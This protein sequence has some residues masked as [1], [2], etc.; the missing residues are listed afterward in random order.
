[1][2]EF[3]VETTD[4]KTLS[5]VFKF[6]PQQN[7]YCNPVYSYDFFNKHFES[8]I[9]DTDALRRECF[10]LRYEVYC[11]E[12]KGFE[13]PRVF[14]DRL[15]HDE[16]DQ[17][18]MH[19]LLRHR[20]T[21]TFVGTSRLIFQTKAAQGNSLPVKR[22]ARENGLVLPELFDPHEVVEIS[23]FCICKKFRQ[24]INDSLALVKINGGEGGDEIRR[25]IP[26]ISVGLLK[27]MFFLLKEH[28][29]KQVC[30]VLDPVF[31]RMLG[32]LGLHFTKLGPVV[33]YHGKR[34]ICYQTYET[35]IDRL[36]QERSDVWDLATEKGQHVPAIRTNLP[37][38]VPKKSMAGPSPAP[39]SYEDAFSR[40]LGWVTEQEQ[41]TLRGKRIAIAGMGGVGGSHLLAMTRLGI[42]AFN[43]ADF[44]R[45]EL[46]NFNRQ[47]GAKLS[48]L[49]LRKA[50]VL[51]GMAKDINPEL[52]LNI[53]S[54][55]VT[56]ENLDAFLDG[57]AVYVDG[58]DFFVLDVRRKIFARCRELGIPAI[59]AA[60]AGMGV[61]YLVFTRNGMSFE[62]YF[63]MRDLPKAKQLVR[64]MLGLVPAGL[65][66][67]YL[68]DKTRFDIEAERA[69][70]TGLAC[71]L[72]AGV[73]ATQVLKLVLQ[74]GPIKPAPHYHHFDA[75]ANRW[76]EGRLPRG[77]RGLLQRL[78]M[79]I[80]MHQL[81]NHAPR[82]EHA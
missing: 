64:F 68:L 8:V 66:R 9:A 44:D 30:G 57:V 19:V 28:G 18:S 29:V 4:D 3:H 80:A 26:A 2:R 81:S 6:K 54:E 51:A 1:M 35:L 31:I 50:E 34:Q 73:V 37:F 56:G 38:P 32:N 20:D 17:D 69:P 42:G 82:Q 70:S 25:L 14:P 16:Y 46:V 63:A 5:A 58:L 12:R 47:A 55:G 40:N 62:D 43:I 49:G 41:Q 65:H 21:N 24:N 71:D 15:E 45:F 33:D 77:N 39:F 27:P 52:Q 7:I 72:C 60:P 10:R 11:V 36:K 13:D 22:I 74:R 59:T 61:A 53:F 76:K 79:V 75:Y 23:R 67:S 48:T 78:K